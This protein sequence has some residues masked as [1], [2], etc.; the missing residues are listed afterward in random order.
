MKKL[1]V[2]SFLMF[3]LIA[4]G[5]KQNLSSLKGKPISIQTQ[6]NSESETPMGTMK[7]DL[8][9]TYIVTITEETTDAYLVSYQLKKVK[10]SVDRMGQNKTYDS[11]EE[12]DKDSPLSVSFGDKIGKTETFKVDKKTLICNKYQTDSA[13]DAGSSQG[14]GSAS[15]VHDMFFLAILD[16][17]AVG[18][19]WVNEKT[20][21]G[22]TTKS[23]YTIKLI[24]NGFATIDVN[25]TK[26]GTTDGKIRGTSINTTIDNKLK[27]EMIV[28]MS[29]GMISKST[30]A[31]DTKS[32][33]NIAGNEMEIK[34]TTKNVTTVSF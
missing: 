18:K 19:T 23:T 7:Q 15:D 24:E 17:A 33:S 14:M 2:G 16:N 1:F 21:K 25:T 20:E 29:T 13:A 22:I 9:S 8:N 10:L 12:S 34:S 11:D 5:Q 26:S 31:G 27:G 3:S 4:F 30:M 6:T 32:T 28:D